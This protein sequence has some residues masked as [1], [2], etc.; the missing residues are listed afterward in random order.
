MRCAGVVQEKPRIFWI[1]RC[2][3][4]RKVELFA[5]P[6]G[7]DCRVR[8]KFAGCENGRENFAGHYFPPPRK[9]DV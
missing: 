4:F 1:F 5:H 7:K 9:I 3:F 2:Y 8:E 6:P